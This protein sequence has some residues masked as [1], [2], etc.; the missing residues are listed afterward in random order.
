MGLAKASKATAT[1][2]LADLV[3]KGCLVRLPEEGGVLGMG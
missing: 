1:R 3:E 2:E